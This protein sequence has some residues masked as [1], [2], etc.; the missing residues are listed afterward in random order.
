MKNFDPED[1]INKDLEITEDFVNFFDDGQIE[2]YDTK[3]K[4]AKIVHKYS[5]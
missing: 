3:L 4:V 2:D 1:K 5:T